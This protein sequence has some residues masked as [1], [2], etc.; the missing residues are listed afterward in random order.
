[1]GEE[2]NITLELLADKLD[3]VVN[4]M[5]TKRDVRK[6]QEDIV[7]LRDDLRNRPTHEELREELKKYRYAKD[8]DF[9]ASR[10]SVCE[11][12][13]GIQPPLAF[14]FELGRESSEE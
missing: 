8:I 4:E 1:M 11:R 13:L 10:V 9:L 7:E 5:A 6:L 14:E 3:V 12:K 2:K